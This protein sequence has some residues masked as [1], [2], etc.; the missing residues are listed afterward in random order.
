MLELLH[1]Y[2]K[3]VREAMTTMAYCVDSV[4]EGG[5]EGVFSPCWW[6]IGTKTKTE[7][8][9]IVVAGGLSTFTD[10][11]AKAK[12]VTAPEAKESQPKDMEPVADKSEYGKKEVIAE[13][14]EEE[15]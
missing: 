11:A 4:E 3:S 8:G 12:A 1:I 2:P 13:S 6:F 7:E 9:K 15:L 5:R 14:E 10:D